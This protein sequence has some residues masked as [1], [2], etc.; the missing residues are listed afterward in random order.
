MSRKMRPIASGPRW[1]LACLLMLS[2]LAAM[3][4]RHIRAAH[5]TQSL[6]ATSSAS[7]L[8]LEQVRR[9]LVQRE[10]VQT[11]PSPSTSVQQAQPAN[12]RPGEILV[13][14]SPG[15]GPKAPQRLAARLGATVLDQIPELHAL[16]L[17]LPDALTFDQAATSLESDQDVA[18]SE[19]NLIL[20]SQRVP[21]D[22]LYTNQTAYLQAIDAPAAWDIQTGDPHVIIAVLDSGIDIEH[23]D[24]QA[25]IWLNR[26]AGPTDGNNCGNDLHGCN[27]VDGQVVDPSCQGASHLAAPNPDITPDF[28]HGTFVAGEIGAQTNNNIGVAGVV[29]HASLMAVRIGDCT[30]PNIDS[31]VQGILYAVHNGARVINMSFGDDPDATGACPQPSQ[32]L[33]QAVQAAEDR[34]GAVLVAPTGDQ[35]PTSGSTAC[36]DYPAAYPQVIAVGATA[37]DGAHAPFSQYGP[38]V[39]VAAPGTDI[40]STTTL[41]PDQQP[42]NDLYRIADGTSFAAPLVAGEAALLISQNHLLTPDQIRSLIQSGAVA[43]DESIAPNWAGAGRIDLAASLRLVPAGFYGKVHASPPVPDGT[44]VEARVGAV[45][46]GTGQTF[47]DN[48]ESVYTVFVPPFSQITGCGLPGAIVDLYVNG[49]RS[50]AT[51]WQASDIRR[52]LSVPSS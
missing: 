42:P 23:P 34:Y 9:A 11:M 6:S 28:W 16:R 3:G 7:Q 52:D 51:I 47:T 5:A 15:A 39:A 50:G 31:A 1:R 19:P 29:W 35:A 38:E 17:G 32:L 44:T 21:T 48:G 46:C 43:V 8:D 14:L 20:Q 13:A 36:V 18:W 4:G 24:L 30:G 49:V 40:V 10:A 22:P 45:S 25:N 33:A 2:G 12:E 26:N 37:Q 41:R 27:F